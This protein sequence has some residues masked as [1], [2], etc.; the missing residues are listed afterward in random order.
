MCKVSTVRRALP[1]P[2]MCRGQGAALLAG[3]TMAA[4]FGSSEA[5]VMTLLELSLVN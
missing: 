4:I 1:P 2:V 5:G 3:L